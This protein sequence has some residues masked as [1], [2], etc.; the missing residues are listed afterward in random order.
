MPGKIGSRITSRLS[1]LDRG[2][3]II[4]LVSMWWGC[5]QTAYVGF[6]DSTGPAD[7]VETD[8]TS[9]PGADSETERATEPD[10]ETATELSPDTATEES[11]DSATALNEPEMLPLTGA[12]RALDPSVIEA[13]GA[14]FMFYTGPWIL[15]K[16]SPDLLDWSEQP[17]VFET[18]P[19]W[20]GEQVPEAVEIWA[21]D[22]TFFNGAYHLYY[23]VS[24]FA[25]N[26]SCIGHAVA[27][28][29]TGAWTDLGSV[30]CSMSEADGAADDWN[31]IDPD[32]VLDED[33]TPFLV[34]GSYWS[35]IKA[36]RLTA[37]G[38]LA[39]GILYPISSRGDDREE[40]AA[41]LVVRRG[42]YYYHFVSFDQCCVGV[43]STHNI[44]VGRARGVLG[45]YF[46]QSGASMTTGGG[47]L[48]VAGDD[49][50]HGPGHNE[51]LLSSL[52][53]FNIFH[54]YDADNNGEPTLRISTLVWSADDWPRSAGP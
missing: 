22:V 8:G 32:I 25:V 33:G 24:S 29:I 54:A 40:T 18:P 52:G 9:E 36:A 13:G 1:R 15:R 19:A 50:W 16:R 7:S 34:F 23:G 20:I 37:D 27:T 6:R 17:P 38:Q 43:D 41:P 39:D 46:D 21:P 11:T 26:H 10:T 53:D 49:R 2:W 5:D 28:E 4:A 31:A 35:G 12:L 47:T 48:L 14:F 3:I 30:I 44:R 45:P 42:E 51:I